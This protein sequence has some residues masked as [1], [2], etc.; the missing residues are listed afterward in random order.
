MKLEVSNP[1][2]VNELCNR[3]T[4]KIHEI[5]ESNTKV[6]QIRVKKQTIEEWITEDI[7]KAIKFRN[8]LKRR[9]DLNRRQGITDVFIRHQYNAEILLTL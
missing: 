1:Q 6:K 9:I 4:E 3:F 5:I 2:N 7:L 8:N